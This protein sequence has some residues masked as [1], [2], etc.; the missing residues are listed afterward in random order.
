MYRRFE[1]VPEFYQALQQGA[2]G[3]EGNPIFYVSSSAW[4]MYDRFAKFMEINNIPLGPML[5]RDIELSLDN[6]LAFEHESHKREQIEPILERFP[7]LPFMLIGDGGQ[8]DAEIYTQLVKAY[9]GR[10][11]A[12]YIRAVVPD[13]AQQQQ[14]LAD[15]K[16]SIAEQNVPL[17]VFDKTQAASVHAVR[18]GWIQA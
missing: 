5:L 17:V 3:N 6:L 18:Q 2:S 4:N 14:I 10:I 8:Q 9:P 12:I 15:F 11:R 7:N 13:N 16:N 1:E